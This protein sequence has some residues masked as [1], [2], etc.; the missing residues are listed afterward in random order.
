MQLK[1]G[2]QTL[3]VVS[4]AAA[5]YE[6]LEKRG[7]TSFD[8]PSSPSPEIITNGNYLGIMGAGMPY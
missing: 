1:V 6:I 7:A 5:A 8:R 4:S 3:V 2:R